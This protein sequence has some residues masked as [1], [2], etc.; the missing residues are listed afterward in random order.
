MLIYQAF[1]VALTVAIDKFLGSYGSFGQVMPFFTDVILALLLGANVS[2]ALIISAA[3]ELAFYGI[4]AIG[5]VLPSDTGFGGKLGIAFAIILHQKPGIAVALAVPIAM[6]AVIVWSLLK[7]WYTFNVDLFEKY[8]KERSMKKFNRLWWIQ[9]SVYELTYAILAFVAILGGTSGVKMFVNSI[10]KIGLSCLNVAA[11][12]LPAVGMAMLLK[13]V[14]NI[15]FLPYFVA[16]FVFA[17]WLKLPIMGVSFLGVAF[18]VAVF[19]IDREMKKI[20]DQKGASNVTKN[21]DSEE[22]FFND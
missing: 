14:W 20:R 18:G 19:F 6:L 1:A 5:G 12:M 7:Y 13:Y 21:T 15:Q 10:P 3:V 22:D 11:G 8:I 2:N 4:I 17:A 9:I 16:G